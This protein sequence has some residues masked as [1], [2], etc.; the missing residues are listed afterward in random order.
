[1]H[2][3]D[4]CR[5]KR[6]QYEEYPYGQLSVDLTNLYVYTGISPYIGTSANTNMDRSPY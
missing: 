3:P 5:D 4:A 6:R 2:D 1:M